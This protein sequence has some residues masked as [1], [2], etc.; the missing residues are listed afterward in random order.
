MSGR[1]KW[2]EVEAHADCLSALSAVMPCDLLTIAPCLKFDQVND[3]C[4]QME[5][6]VATGD[7][8]GG[9]H[10]DAERRR[11]RLVIHCVAVQQSEPGG[12]QIV[13]AIEQ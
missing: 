9:P 6:N 11:I 7:R 2:S 12:S 8:C 1:R 5:D 13:R 3:P 4:T 10:V